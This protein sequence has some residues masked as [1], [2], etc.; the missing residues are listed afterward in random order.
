MLDTQS[1][2]FHF[3]FAQFSV[4]SDCLF[5]AIGRYGKCV[6]QREKEIERVKQHARVRRPCNIAPLLASSG[7]SMVED[8]EK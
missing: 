7:G 3:T 1:D 8:A 6:N 4:E 5:P 2:L